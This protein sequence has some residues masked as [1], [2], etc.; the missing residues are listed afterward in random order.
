MAAYRAGRA[1]FLKTMLDRPRIF[2]GDLFHARYDAA[3]R[4]NLTRALAR[5][6]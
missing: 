3:A 1:K 6:A 5:Y 4:T 2:L